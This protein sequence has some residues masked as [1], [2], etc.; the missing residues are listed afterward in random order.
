LPS[1]AR[2]GELIL[3]SI[4][5]VAG[6]EL[7]EGMTS[8]EEVHAVVH[9]NPV[10]LHASLSTAHS[11]LTQDE[12]EVLMNPVEVPWLLTT[13]RL[14]WLT[15]AERRV[16]LLELAHLFTQPCVDISPL[17]VQQSHPFAPVEVEWG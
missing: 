15:Y 12:G 9:T 4:A 13:K 1:H 10:S 14:D 16:D 7:I 2:V 3:S 8:I 11:E 5:L 6:S 17:D